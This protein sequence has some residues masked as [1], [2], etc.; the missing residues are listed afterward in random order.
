MSPWI[1]DKPERT[2][3]VRDFGPV[4]HSHKTEFRAGIEQ[5]F[6]WTQSSGLSAGEPA[7][8]ASG[9]AARG[10]CRAF[11]GTASQ[12]SAFK[13]G[14]LMVTSDPTRLVAI[15]S[16]DSVLIGSARMIVANPTFGLGND[17]QMLVQSDQGSAVF[18]NGTRNVS[19]DTVYTQIPIVTAGSKINVDNGVSFL[20]ISNVTT[21]GFEFKIENTTGGS[22][23]IWWRAVGS[24]AI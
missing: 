2:D 5:H 23:E 20:A 1:E 13:D 16:A 7:L 12:V 3:F 4:I 6:L 9:A 8:D 19:F 11:Y 22:P 21:G 17:E 15:T 10:T 18:A 14:S 24:A